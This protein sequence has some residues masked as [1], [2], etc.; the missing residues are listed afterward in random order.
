MTGADLSPRM[1]ERAARRVMADGN[2]VYDALLE[3][4]LVTAL[5]AP[6]VR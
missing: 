5:D 1:L 6:G 3:C 2:R 4:D